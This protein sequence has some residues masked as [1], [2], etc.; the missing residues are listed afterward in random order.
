[1]TVFEINAAMEERLKATELPYEKINVFGV[2]R[3]NV[4][5]KCMARE[6]AQK[7]AL[8]LNEIFPMG[9]VTV[10][11]TSWDAIEN[12][13]TSMVKTKVSGFLVSI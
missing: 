3:Q 2:I 13:G 4:H 1:M 8:L 11:N 7:W 6:T 9:K 10:T 5:I 12:K